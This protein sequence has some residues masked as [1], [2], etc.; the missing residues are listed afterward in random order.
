MK[1]TVYFVYL[2]KRLKNNT[3]MYPKE[4]GHEGVDL[5]C[6]TQNRG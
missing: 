4:V 6:L 5:I 3:K 1:E 2:G